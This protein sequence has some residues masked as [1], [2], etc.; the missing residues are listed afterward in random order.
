MALSSKIAVLAASGSPAVAVV[1]ACHRCRRRFGKA[2]GLRI[3]G[4]AVSLEALR[5]RAV[6]RR[7]RL[8]RGFEN[9]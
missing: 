6:R 4:L 1:A 3:Q 7:T 2:L 8:A 9:S 5:V